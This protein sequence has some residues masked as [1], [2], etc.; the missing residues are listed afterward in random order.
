MET[1][2]TNRSSMPHITWKEKLTALP[3]Q[4]KSTCV[5]KLGAVNSK[6]T[7]RA[8]DLGSGVQQQLRAKPAMWAAVAAGAGFGVG[9]LGRLMRRRMHRDV[10]PTLIIVEAC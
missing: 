4:V 9:M 3:A 7:S 6:V 8:R 1:I 10:I 2:E 5:T